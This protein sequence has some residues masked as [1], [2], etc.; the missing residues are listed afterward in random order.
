LRLPN[1]MTR[2]VVTVRPDMSLKAVAGI[3]AERRISGVPVVDGD[4][5]VVGIVS[6]GDMLFKEHGPSKRTGVLS[7]LL[8]PHGM[9]GH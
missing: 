6:E 1:V 4:G 7:W 2:E 5:E 9:E 8:D 3:L